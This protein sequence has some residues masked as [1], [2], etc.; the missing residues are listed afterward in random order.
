[1]EHCAIDLGGRKSQV[2]VRASD[3]QVRWE[4]RCETAE[5]KGR[6]HAWPGPMRVVLETCAEAF[7]VADAALAAGHEVRVVPATLVKTLGVGARRTKT[8]RRD[9]QVLSEVSC[10][11]NLPSVHVSSALSRRRKTTC[12]MREA[13][14]VARTGLVNTVRSWLRSQ[15]STP[16]RTGA[17]ETFTAR[18]R[19]RVVAEERPGYVERQLEAIDSLSQKIAEANEEL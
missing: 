16:L 2:C 10:R 11:I 5:L 12:G 7:G 1:M 17:V 13:L 14:V 9:A 6:L 19:A 4:E 8:D 18:V 15:A 3:G